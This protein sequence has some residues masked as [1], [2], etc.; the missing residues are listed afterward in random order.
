MDEGETTTNI[1]P[2]VFC[3]YNHYVLCNNSNT[4]EKYATEENNPNITKIVV[5]EP[6]ECSGCQY[7]ESEATA[8]DVTSFLDI[9]GNEL[10]PDLLNLIKEHQSDILK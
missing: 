4:L 5:H 6:T 1:I 2:Q 8:D 10:D 3:Y 9:I 7:S